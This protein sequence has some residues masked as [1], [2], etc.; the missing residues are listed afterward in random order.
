MVLRVAQ[1]AL[2]GETSPLGREFADNGGVV[3][4]ASD[5]GTLG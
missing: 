3:L 5:G 4:D 1:L 2:S